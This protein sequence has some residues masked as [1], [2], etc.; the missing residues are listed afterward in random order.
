LTKHVQNTITGL[1]GEGSPEFPKKERHLWILCRFASLWLTSSF[2]SL[3]I[4]AVD[5]RDRIVQNKRIRL[6][7]LSTMRHIVG[8][9]EKVIE[10]SKE[11]TV[12]DLLRLILTTYSEKVS[13]LLF[14]E[15]NK[16]VR[17]DILI[18]INDVDMDVLEGVD[19]VLSEEDEV[20]LMPIAHGG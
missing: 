12:G 7:F 17:N 5:L 10:L 15:D 11:A 14:E 9:N 19:T 3:P 6:R 18:L 4:N 2:G 16:S 20:T 13:T 1:L 8:E